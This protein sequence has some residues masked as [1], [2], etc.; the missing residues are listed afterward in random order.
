MDSLSLDS[1]LSWISTWTSQNPGT[2]G[3]V[4]FATAALESLFLV[5]VVVPGALV[6]VSAGAL[7]AFDL[8]PLWPTLAWAAAGAAVGDGFSFWIG[9]HF[10]DRL[11]RLRR[12]AAL[13]ERGEAF[14]HRHGGKSVLLGRFVG[15]I[16]AV[17]PT[18]AGAMGMSPLR[19]A[20]VNVLSALL[21]APAYILPGV[22][23]GASLELASEVAVRLVIMLLVLLLVVAVTIWIVRRAFRFLAPRADQLAQRFLGWSARHPRLGP[24]GAALVDPRH[25]ES[26][27]L[28][29]FALLLTIAG[30][31]F[32]LLLG[33]VL[34]TPAALRLD[35]PVHDLLQSLRTPWMDDLMVAATMLADAWF[36]VPYSVLILALLLLERNP[37]AALHWLAAVGIPVAMSRAIKFLVATP[38]PEEVFSGILEYGFPSAHATVAAAMFGFLAVLIAR[39]LRP[40]A[41]LPTYSAAGAL[42]VL[43]ATSRMYLG[44]HWLSDS[45][46][47]LTLGL[48][49]AALLGIAYRRHH[50]PPLHGRRLVIVS[51]L[52]LLAVGALHMALHFAEERERYR[53]APPVRVLAG[54]WDGGWRELP[55]FRDDLVAAKPN[56]FNL[57]WAGDLV[58]LQEHLQERGW[59]APVGGARRSLY[60]LSP[61]ASLEQVPVLP[62]VHDGRHQAL[63]LRRPGAEPGTQYVLRLWPANVRLRP[64]AVPLW[65]GTVSLQSLRTRLGLFRYAVT[66]DEFD[67]P[68]AALAADL[69]SLPSRTVQRD[70][71][72]AG[73]NGETLLA[74]PQRAPGGSTELQPREQR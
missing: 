42:I 16:R 36:Y 9:R 49:W 20:A 33:Q 41:R 57:Q 34:E 8:L 21:W 40:A 38:R 15:P 73:W 54:W 32:A 11:R 25:P 23:F 7:V 37:A 45:M 26:P 24:L 31:G 55:V 62:Q 10:R 71:G 3:L 65:L 68:L 4:I 74:Q 2:T 53:V 44:V 46:G 27:A 35:E 63:L 72:A 70:T 48:A 13:L 22:A 5:G 51:V 52:G 61:A 50:S 43:I 69:R 30:V 67:R 59:E 47:G 39:E 6:M 60:W 1:V 18:V 28:L 14:F 12:S 19:F 17:I 58:V 56:P 29:V 66:T 64:G